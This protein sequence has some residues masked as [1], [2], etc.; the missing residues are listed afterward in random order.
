MQGSA[1]TEQREAFAADSP[2]ASDLLTTRT[3]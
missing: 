3:S 2:A 1:Q